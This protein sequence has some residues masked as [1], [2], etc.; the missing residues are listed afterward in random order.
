MSL[1]KRA[2]LGLLP[3]LTL[4]SGCIDEEYDCRRIAACPAV[5]EG[6]DASTAMALADGDATGVEDD[7]DSGTN[8]AAALDNLVEETGQPST[9]YTLLITRGASATAYLKASNTGAYDFFG[10]S[11][12]LSGD[13]STLAVG[14]EG[15]DSAGLGVGGNG[16]DDD[17]SGSGAV[18]IFVRADDGWIQQ[19]YLKADNTGAEDRFGASLALSDD[20]NT[21]AVGADGED[22]GTTGT[23]GAGVDNDEA[24]NAGA[25]YVFQRTGSGWAQQ[26]YLKAENAE[27]G[28]GFGTAVAL[29]DDGN[30]LA[31]G[32]PYEDSNATGS[33]GSGQGNN[34]ARNAGAT[35]V[36]RRSGSDWSQQAY[37]K[38]SN[39]D[40][41]DAFGASLAL[42]GDGSTLAVGAH[43]EDSSASGTSGAGQADNDAEY[44]GAVY[45]FTQDGSGWPQQAYL[46]A[47]EAEAFDY[48]GASLAL[49][50][51]GD[52]LAVGAHGDDGD[53]AEGAGSGSARAHGAAYVFVRNN[54]DWTQQAY[55]RAHN[56]GEGD[57]FGAS[58]ALTGDGSTLAVG[59]R[60]EDGNAI[61][62]SAGEQDNDAAAGSGA[63]YVFARVAEAWSQQVYVKA[64]NTGIGDEFGWSVALAADGSMLAVGARYEDSS[65]AGPGAAQSDDEARDSGAVY[66][67]Q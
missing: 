54:D 30:T 3:L 65:F 1:P 43:A 24:T 28:D 26:G 38:A 57:Y 9:N 42:S 14:A 48:F 17:A 55:L 23:A 11:I 12:A 15:E 62:A 29:S 36:F 63:V 51:D 45:V 27:A 53:S 49:S 61:G 64:D 21:L 56:R 60:G 13:G 67:F 33:S 58:L 44:A 20:G 4:L 50:G 66:L 18:Y 39:T 34:E 46:K 7:A 37:L 40:E 41:D 59:A 19:A 22:S 25:V 2:M 47:S 8:G 16:D 6:G 35:Y 32:A 5:V 52:T 10:M 31:V